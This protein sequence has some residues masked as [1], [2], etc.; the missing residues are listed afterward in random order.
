ME[1]FHFDPPD[2]NPPDGRAR[3]GRD[4]FPEDESDALAELELKRRFE[5]GRAAGG[6]APDASGARG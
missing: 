5:A 3:E 2:F 6:S 1:P 4:D